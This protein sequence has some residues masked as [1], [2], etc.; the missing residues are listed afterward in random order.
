MEELDF[1]SALLHSSPIRPQAHRLMDFEGE[2]TFDVIRVWPEPACFRH[3][4]VEGWLPRQ[5]LL[6]VRVAHEP[7][8]EAEFAG[9]DEVGWSVPLS[10]LFAEV[11][12]QVRE[13]LMPQ[14]VGVCWSVLRLAH[15]VPEVLSLV[16][17]L[18]SLGGLLALEAD[19]HADRARICGEIRAGLALPRRH[20]LP[21]VEL[22]PR[23]RMLRI[24][25]RLDP[26]ALGMPGPAWLKRVLGDE[27]PRVRKWLSHLP[28]LRPDVM[29]VLGAPHLLPLAT[30]ELLGD[31]SKAIFFGLHVYL[32]MA[33]EAREAGDI[34]LTPA[35]F[36]SRDE[37]LELCLHLPPRG[38]KRWDASEFPEPFGHPT[39]SVVLTGSPQVELQPVRT[40]QEMLDRAIPDGL[41]IS[42]Q[43]RY[44]ERAQAGDGALYVASWPR[45]ERRME[46]T[47]WLRL[48]L[49]NGW[50]VMEAALSRNRPVPD[51]LVG[52]LSAWAD[53][54]EPGLTEPLAE[55]P[56]EPVYPKQLYLP[57]RPRHSPFD[58][59][60]AY[61]QTGVF[62]G[63]KDLMFD[64]S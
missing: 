53:D 35:R 8:E 12:A 57:L 2:R 62:D 47:V 18:P 33:L 49:A 28:R 45:G 40:A 31:E 59:P 61:G 37:L 27:T 21:L 11:P 54:L 23:E 26:W 15:D 5:P 51:W 22:E 30:F 60:S 34:P 1:T 19:D 43:R 56:Q 25:R 10:P 46:A 29:I 58:I 4:P 64:D 32:R 55:G 63:P 36:R 16:G 39:T 13:A 41:C 50:R 38:A 48:S 24:L 14:D 52:R 9:D 17:D 42:S 7:P 3:T 44:A 6:H 20:L